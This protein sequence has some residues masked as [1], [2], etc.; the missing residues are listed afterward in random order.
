MRACR[1][2]GTP[3]T[4]GRCARCRASSSG[5]AAWASRCATRRAIVG[6][7][8]LVQ[9]IAPPATRPARCCATRWR[10]AGAEG[11]GEAFV[12]VDPQGRISH[13][14]QRAGQVLAPRARPCRDARS[15]ASSRSVRAW[16]W[17]SASCRRWSG[18]RASSDGCAGHAG[19]SCAAFPSAP[20]S[21]C[22]CGTCRKAARQQHLMLLERQHRPPQRHR[23]HHRSRA[24]RRAGPR[25]VFVNEA[26]ERRT[27]WRRDEVIGQSPR[28]LQGPDTQRA[29]LDRIRGAL[30][31]WEQVRVDLVNY[32]RTGQPYWVDL[33]VSPVWDDARR[34]RTGSPSGATS[35]SASATRKDPVPCLLRPAHRCPTARCCWAGWSRRR[36]RA[37]R[38]RPDVHRPGQL[39]GVERHAGAPEG[40]PAAAAG[41]AAAA[42]LRR[43][44][45]P[46]R[47]AGRRRVRGAAGGHASRSRWIP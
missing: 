35:P 44:G 27:G 33:D 22:T 36:A 29:Q 7:E 38:E 20:A 1:R 4:C 18:A 42:Q 12:T 41:G 19:W 43:Q 34:S 28:I 37:A 10:A 26:F 31:Q 15:G 11:S 47:A 9:E 2:A 3:S 6:V 46:G 13:A 45:R 14:N 32:T 8:G 17:R 40:R 5:C 21:R 24:L 39:Q 25:I 30:E 16:R 23:H